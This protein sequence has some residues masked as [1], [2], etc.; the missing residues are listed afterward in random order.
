MSVADISYCY[1]SWMFL[2]V[3]FNISHLSEMLVLSW[4]LCS[5]RY[6]L[7][8]PMCCFVVFECSSLKSTVLKYQRCWHW[9]MD[10]NE[11]QMNDEPPVKRSK[12]SSS[13]CSSDNIGHSQF[14]FFH[15]SHSPSS[16]K[17]WKLFI[18]LE[19]NSGIFQ[20]SGKSLNMPSVLES[21]ESLN[22]MLVVLEFGKTWKCI[23]QQ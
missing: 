4:V 20:G 19:F 8:I 21:Y 18:I 22:F 17:R 11:K 7:C 2:S 13:P 10:H 3:L 16:L 14:L 6:S 9:V 15:F 23:K 5:Y 12:L 1:T